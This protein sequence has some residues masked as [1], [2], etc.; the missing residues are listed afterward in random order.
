MNGSGSVAKDLVA[1]VAKSEDEAEAIIH[2]LLRECAEGK[3][4]REL[5]ATGLAI[6]WA[7]DVTWVKES[8]AEARRKSGVFISPDAQP[9]EESENVEV[10]PGV[11]EGFADALDAALAKPKEEDWLA[12]FRAKRRA[13]NLLGAAKPKAEEP[14]PSVE[15]SVEASGEASVEV[16]RPVVVPVAGVRAWSEVIYPQG[17]SELERLT[18][19][20]G[21]LGD[22]IEWIIL[23]AHRPHRMMAMGSGIAVIGTL[24]GRLVEG[25]T[26]S[27]THLQLINLAGSGFGKAWPSRAGKLLLQ[28]VKSEELLGPEEIASSPGFFEYVA[29][30]PLLVC[31]MDEFATELEKISTQANNVFVSAMNATF[32]KLYNCW[33]D[34]KTAAKV[35]KTPLQI[36]SPAVS[37]VATATPEA[38]FEAIRPKDVESGFFNRFLILPWSLRR[39]PER[40]VPPGADNVPKAIIEGLKRIPKAPKISVL[41]M[42]AFTMAQP[43]KEKPSHPPP[44]ERMR[45]HFGDGAE[46]IYRRFSGEVDGWAE[47]N[48]ERYAAAQRGHSP[49]VVQRAMM[50]ALINPLPLSGRPPIKPSFPMAKRPGQNHE[51]PR[52][53]KV[54]ALALSSDGPGGLGFALFTTTVGLL[55]GGSGGLARLA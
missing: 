25:P 19:V 17:A 35:G 27:S 40:I 7:L 33:E 8:F 5:V 52:T 44:K 12:K 14:K 51:M 13:N 55:G 45:M 32:K 10:V 47:T 22:V 1:I 2:A 36:C 53:M 23:G 48:P 42:P 50:S 15:A 21:L 4:D 54:D 34:H 18:Y 37:I 41:D 43:G 26:G 30:H 46:A 9:E 6:K 38:F 3:S 28:S 39:A 24:C 31:Y 11:G 49:P 20:P 16:A 29:D